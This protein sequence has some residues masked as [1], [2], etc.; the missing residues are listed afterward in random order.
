MANTLKRLFFFKIFLVWGLLATAQTNLQY[1]YTDTVPPERTWIIDSIVFEGNKL[2]LT[3]VLTRE[4]LIKSGDTLASAQLHELVSKTCSN[5]KN[6]SLF[7]F[8][9]P[10]YKFKSMGQVTVKFVV[11]ERW[12]VWPYPVFEIADRNFN[13]WWRAKNFSRVNYGINLQIENFRGR[14]ETLAILAKLGFDRRFGFH[15]TIPSINQSQTLGISVAYSISANHEVAYATDSLNQINFIRND[16]E[17]L[18][19]EHQMSFAVVYR[20]NFYQTHTAELE[21]GMMNLHQEVLD[22][23]PNYGPLSTNFLSFHYLLKDDHRDYKHYPLRG[24]Y[25]D[26]V[27]SKIGIPMLDEGNIDYWS[28]EGTYRKY[29]SFN[30]KWFAAVGAYGRLVGVGVLPYFIQ[31]GLGYGRYFVRGYEYYVVDGQKIALLKANLKYA[32][33]PTRILKI[34][35]LK[36]EKFSKL[37][38][39]FYINLFADAGYAEGKYKPDETAL[40][41]KLLYSVGLGLDFVTYYDKVLRVEYSVNR[42]GESGFFVHFI[43]SI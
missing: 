39:A 34:N 6:L 14:K 12:Y 35:Q 9:T 43:S 7:N 31:S 37:H 10:T 25:I 2:T 40:S 36:T 4:L 22:K 27:A 17:F 28:L 29:W 13:V 11:V 18:K 24:Y 23:N 41:G 15:Y 3:K 21:F 20:P 32:L 42:L 19:T 16:N 5:L 26:M 38:Y 33:V 1:I 8:V 30:S